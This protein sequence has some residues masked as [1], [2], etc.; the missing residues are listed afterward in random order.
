[1]NLR[2]GN[3]A[4][5]DAL[6]ALQLRAGILF[7]DAGLLAIADSPPTDAAT[8]DASIRD[9]LLHVAMIADRLAGFTLALQSEADCHLEQMS[10]DPAFGRRGVGGVLLRHLV[11]LARSRGC[12]RVTL[13][14]FSDLAWNGPFYE[15]FGFAYVPSGDLTPAL[16]DV[17]RLEAEAGLDMS[18]RAI[19]ALHL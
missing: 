5:V 11:E 17:R 13:S 6:Q 16:V 9:D 10:V 14:T 4:D 12:E 18:R 1:M 15:R 7:R 19:M 8:F 2:A 3:S